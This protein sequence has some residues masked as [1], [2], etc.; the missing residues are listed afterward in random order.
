MINELKWRLSLFGRPAL[1]EAEGRV[2]D[3]PKKAF[4]IAARLVLDKPKLHSS[5]AE[6]AEFLWSD[7]DALRRQTSLRTLLKRIRFA[8]QG[9]AS[10]P[11][12]ID[13][14]SVWLDAQGVACDLID[15]KRLL[16][17]GHP[18]DVV[19]AAALI[20]GELV[21]NCESGSAAFENWLA[22]QRS[23]LSQA[24]LG[25]AL[26]VLENDDSVLA[27]P[28][29]ERL[30]Q[31]VIS[32]NPMEEAAYRALLK[33]Y[34]AQRNFD[35]VRLTYD[36]LLRGLKMEL[37]CQP[38]AE[39]RALFSELVTRGEIG[40]GVA[41]GPSHRKMGGPTPSASPTPNSQRP[42]LIVPPNLIAD[43]ASPLGSGGSLVDDLLV[44]LWKP[45]S[46]R[47]TVGLVEEGPGPSD[48]ETAQDDVYRL[49]LGCRGGEC[50]RLSARLTHA[51]GSD[52]LWAETFLLTSERYDDVVA[53]TADA[54]LFKIEDHQIELSS[55]RPC[56]K[57]TG[58]T[59]VAQAERALL[60]ADLPSIRRARRLL[61]TAV[62]NN[63]NSP[64]AQAGLA[65]TF[66]MEWLLRTG[67][68]S[69]LLTNA[70]SIARAAVETYPDSHA[71]HQEFGATAL[72]SGDYEL[73]LDHLSRARELQPFDN[74]LVFDFADA[75]ISNGQSREAIELIKGANTN[76]YRLAEFRHWITASGLYV[77]GE[78]RLAIAELQAMKNPESTYR[79]QAA[80][81]AM[82]GQMDLAEYFK[83][84][85]F[86]E[87]PDFVLEKWLTQVPIRQKIDL[88]HFRD[89][90]RLAG[91]R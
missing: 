2:I 56:E 50:M 74:S 6:L 47:I 83:L 16:A 10:P 25:A 62:Q 27:G 20:S 46:L 77:L 42:L 71:A 17:S 18:R 14:E 58:F 79:L 19:E 11:I 64:R 73:A 38:S 60:R 70:R 86:E 75:L 61:R 26:R 81:E 51:P 5:R 33:I 35:G 29:K 1:R 24:F 31:K 41:K 63:S 13:D 85:S 22:Q 59:L 88:D 87:H 12:V 4:V 32:D 69:S 3:L 23:S 34:A 72:Y 89:G 37:G 76:D 48:T 9:D 30:A 91:F 40:A 84:K 7:S 55:D 68:D 44:Q 39:T 52:L 54:I 36:R 15:F 21:E 78:Y 66:R 43:S 8:L 57:R 65:R 67:Q 80:C 45:R 53:R 90:C 49:H 28:W 82:L